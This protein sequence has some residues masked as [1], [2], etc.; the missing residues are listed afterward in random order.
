MNAA[1]SRA[2][3]KMRKKRF[4]NPDKSNIYF[5]EKE[6][7]IGVYFMEKELTYTSAFKYEQRIIKWHKMAKYD[8]L[9]DP[10][11]NTQEREKFLI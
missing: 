4:N 9:N 3:Q 1:K 7:E 10:P 6:A 5:S 11:F 2:I 8:Y